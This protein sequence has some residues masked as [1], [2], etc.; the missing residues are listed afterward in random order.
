[1]GF[2]KADL[3][4]FLEVIANLKENQ[5]PIWGKMSAQRMI[6]H[7]TDSIRM[8]CGLENNVLQVPE[9]KIERMQAFLASEKPMAK[10]IEVSFAKE[11]TPLRN[12]D[13]ELAIDEFTM[14]WV[15]FE[16]IYSEDQKKVA[17]HPHY[18]HLNYE[19]WIALHIKHFTHHFSQFGLIPN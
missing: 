18:G 6:E 19:K 11:N 4:F 1:M 10:N 13:M 15:D 14:A 12:L 8:S 5:K 17:V 16:E 3:G 2:V 7:L 9:E